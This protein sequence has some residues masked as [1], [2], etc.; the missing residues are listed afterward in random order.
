MANK[1][2]L[3]NALTFAFSLV[4]YIVY[5]F[6]ITKNDEKWMLVLALIYFLPLFVDFA[7][8]VVAFLFF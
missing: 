3:G 8:E 2:F 5:I 7:E 1:S 4:A 6:S